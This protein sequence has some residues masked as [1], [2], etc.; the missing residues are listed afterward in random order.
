MENEMVLIIYAAPT[1][2]TQAHQPVS[3][4]D[5]TVW[6]RVGCSDKPLIDALGDAELMEGETLCNAIPDSF[7]A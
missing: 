5:K 3:F 7:A 1:Q 2:L 4:R 6:I